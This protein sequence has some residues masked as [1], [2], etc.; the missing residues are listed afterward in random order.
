MYEQY[1]YTL[2]AVGIGVEWRAGSLPAG[3]S[4][5]REGVLKGKSNVP[6]DEEVYFMVFNDA[7]SEHKVMRLKIAGDSTPSDPEQ[8]SQNPYTPQPQGQNGQTTY[9]PQPQGQNGQNFYIVPERG[10]SDQMPGIEID[11][12][13]DSA[14]SSGG[15]CS[16]GP[17][18]LW[19]GAVAVI[20]LRRR[21]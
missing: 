17:G 1:E 18:G 2:E 5:S 13:G 21:R 16:Y 11:P 19:C 6:I 4:F 15:G 14:E 8:N 12:D 9:T 10:Q 20:L 7:G 3:F